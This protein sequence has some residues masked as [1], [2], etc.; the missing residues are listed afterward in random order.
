MEVWKNGSE[1][2][3]CRSIRVNTLKISNGFRLWALGVN[4]CMI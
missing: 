3:E 1:V 2:Y 4:E